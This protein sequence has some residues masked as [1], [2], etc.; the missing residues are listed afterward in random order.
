M[1]K[2]LSRLLYWNIK[3]NRKLWSI[4]NKREHNPRWWSNDELKLFSDYYSGDVLNVSAGADKDKD[5]S[6]YREYFKKAKSY[7]ITNYVLEDVDGYDQIELDLEKELNPQLKNQYELV[8]NHTI[9]EHIYDTKA[10]ISNM[11]S[12]SN[13]TVISV[14]PWMQPYH[15]VENQYKDWWR[16]SPF[17]LVQLFNEEGFK[18]LY[19]NWNKDPFG[20]IYIFHIAS[21]KPEN[22]NT[23]QQ[24]TIDT[25]VDAPGFFHASVQSKT[26]DNGRIKSLTDL[27]SS[28]EKER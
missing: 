18:T 26:G 15:H 24:K 6:C 7:T 25:T 14:V 17:S 21:K 4:L 16:F 20:Y 11:C 12:M 1:K 9:L 10:A 3:L 5:G 27:I 23:I 19:I 8:F 22:W 2:Q 28:W 13:D